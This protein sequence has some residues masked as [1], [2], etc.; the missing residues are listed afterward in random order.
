MRATHIEPGRLVELRV[1]AQG[2]VGPFVNPVACAQAAQAI[3]RRG[4]VWASAVCGRPLV[5]R[6]R[7]RPNLPAL[8]SGEE[9]LLALA[10][11]EEDRARFGAI[12]RR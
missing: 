10:D 6:S 2:R 4:E 5:E 9:E 1:E 8:R 7:L 12:V 11:V 3:R